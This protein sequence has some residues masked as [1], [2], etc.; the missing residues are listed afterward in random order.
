MG[1]LTKMRD[2]IGI[3]KDKAS[4]SKAAFLSKPSTSLQLSLL[5]ATTHDPSAPPS[6]KH[7]SALLS[8]GNS[9]RAIASAAIEALM[10]R[11]QSTQNSAV[12]LKCLLVV[13]H[14]IKYGSFILQ[15]QLSIYPSNG[16]RNYLNLSNFRDN[17]NPITW[18]LSS[19]VRWYA[20]YIEHLLCTSRVLGFFLGSSSRSITEDKEAREQKVSSLLN[21]DLLRETDSLV[22]LVEENCRNPDSV[23][24]SGNKLVDEIINLAS[25]D[26]VSTITEVSIRV[27]EF[28]ER[29]GSLTFGEAVDLVCNLKRLEDCKRV[30]LVVQ[31]K[32]KPS[33]DGF[34]DLIR[35]VKERIG[36]EKLYREEGKLRKERTSESARFARRVL[37]P[38]A[39]VRFPSGRLLGL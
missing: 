30:V 26:C 22:G 17:S 12:A 4:Q 33:M 3:I 38:G 28:N 14:I 10:D 39:L 11:L 8:F 5:R 2:L 27:N 6:R 31:T 36:M 21:N 32:K 7:I 18:E 34:W 13:H 15:D 29:I 25:E 9:S 16:G 19:W 20:Q 24:A 35:E 23:H 37:N 1:Q